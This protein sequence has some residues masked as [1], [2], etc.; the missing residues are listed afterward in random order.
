ML[1]LREAVFAEWE[2]RVRGSLDQARKLPHPILIDTLPPFYN[3]IAESLTLDYPRIVATR[4]TNLASEHGGERARITSYDHEALIEE[5]QLFRWVIFEVLYREGLQLS[6]REV[7]A[8][9]ASIDAG[10]KEAVAGFAVADRM[11]RERFAAAIT[12]DLRGPLGATS[13]ALELILIVDDLAKTRVLAV[14]ALDNVHRMNNMISE[15]LHTMA[16]HAGEQVPLNLSNF[17]I[18]ELVKEVQVDSTAKEQ[19]FIVVSGPRASGWWDRAAM[20][21]ALENLVG[22]AIKYGKE[23]TPI[24]IETTVSHERLLLSVHNQGEPI[25]PDEQESIFRMFKRSN[26]AHVTRQQGW[27]I[28]LPYVR[29]V[30]ESHGGS[31]VLDSTEG[32]GTTFTIDVPIDCRPLS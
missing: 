14:K 32:R 15:L 8:I 30:A 7:L 22:N 3:N 5:Y 31:I 21:R 18:L 11:L 29:A 2:V 24:S 9:N 23:N 1:D 17:E 13:T 10:I 20:K 12:H 27:G 16:F 26:N 4:G 19:T 28:G 6:P 25:P